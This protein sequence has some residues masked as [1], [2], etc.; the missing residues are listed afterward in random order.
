MKTVDSRDTGSIHV[1]KLMSL[2]I[3]LLISFSVHAVD[4]LN[5]TTTAPKPDMRGLDDK[6]QNLKKEVLGLNRDLFVL[7]EELL[8]P[9]TSQVAVFL[10]IDVGEFFKLDSVQLKI[11]NKNVTN[12]LY[13]EREIDALHRGGVQRL[14]VGNLKVGKHELVASFVGI[15]PR[16]REYKRGSTMIFEKK[17][18]AK[19]LELQIIDSE[20]RHQPEFKVK[21][22]E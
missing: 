9:A 15:G 20:A 12:Y 10:S 19:Y 7:E 8:F 3:A 4:P 21:E 11:N 6:I 1:N 14:F 17:T 5:K 2:T 13:T 16:G 22:W 18:D